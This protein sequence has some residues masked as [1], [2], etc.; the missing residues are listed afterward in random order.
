MP[1]PPSLDS[2]PSSVPGLVVPGVHLTRV[3]G[4]AGFATVYAGT[5]VSL[6][7]PVAVKVDA[8]TL[9]DERNRHR[10]LREVSAASRISNHPHAVSLIDAGVLVDGRPFLV[11][12]LCKGGRRVPRGRSR[13]PLHHRAAVR[14]MDLHST[15]RAKV[16]HHE[17]LRAQGAVPRGPGG[18]AASARPDPTSCEWPT[19]P[20]RAPWT[21]GWCACLR[22][23]TSTPAGSSAGR[24]PASPQDRPGP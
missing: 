11:M 2:A 16:A 23:P 13:G 4:R 24:P 8:R 19:P 3:L 20:V 9:D 15:R 7:R 12:E 1:S 14:A 18:P 5:Q 10:F 21:G 17:A 6:S 22:P